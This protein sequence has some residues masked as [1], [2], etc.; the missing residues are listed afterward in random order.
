MYKM[1]KQKNEN[2]S[3]S[4]ES[5]ECGSTSRKDFKNNESDDLSSDLFSEE[6][7]QKIMF[8]FKQVVQGKVIHDDNYIKETILEVD[9]EVGELPDV[10]LGNKKKKSLKRINPKKIQSLKQVFAGLGLS[11]QKIDIKC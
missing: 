11:H 6:S 10:M 2:A 1:E 3:S 5:L 8:V 9:E 4:S 7:E